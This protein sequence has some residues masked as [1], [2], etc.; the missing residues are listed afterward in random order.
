M[1]W[2][3]LVGAQPGA[4]LS[5]L[6]LIA[7]LTLCVTALVKSTDKLKDLADLCILLER[8]GLS[9]HAADS[10]EVDMD[11]D[12]IEQLSFG[13]IPEA[14]I[15]QALRAVFLA[16]ALAFEECRAGFAETEA[17]NLRPYYRRAK[18]EGYLRDAADRISG[19]S[20]TVVQADKSNW[21]HTEIRS[22]PVV[23]TENSVAYP[24]GPVEKA[25]FR[26][27]LARDTV[28][29]DMSQPRLWVEDEGPEP[30]GEMLYVLLLHS[31][32]RWTSPDDE[33]QFGYLPGSAYLAYPAPGL[34]YY[35]HE[36]NLF[37]RYPDVVAPHMPAAWN[38]EAQVRYLHRAR[39]AAFG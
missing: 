32:S 5:V 24:C 35:R 17:E 38:H 16:H 36:I 14:Y 18:L 8:H 39:K 4:R 22:G 3:S 37:D 15:Q 2:R 29:R 6:N 9:R 7:I 21:W 31:R 13:H 27:A 20:A 30:G 10:P 1:I 23:L 25:G 11:I 28:A 34:E 12:E 26:L 33:R 19:V